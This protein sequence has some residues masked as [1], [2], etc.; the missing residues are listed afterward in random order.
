MKRTVLIKI[1]SFLCAAAALFACLLLFRAVET[2]SAG[3]PDLF[4]AQLSDLNER[5][6]Q[7]TENRLIVKSSRKIEDEHCIAS[8][9]GFADLYV[10]QY[11]SEGE[12]AR[13]LEYYSSLGSVQYAYRDAVFTADEFDGT[14]AETT[15]PDAAESDAGSHLSWGAD[16]LGVDGFYD[17]IR[18]KYEGSELPDI[19]VAV[20]DTGVDTDHPLLADRIAFEYGI[21]YCG[22]A[23]SGYDFEDDNDH[24]THV[25]GIIA[26]L[27]LPNVKLIPVKVMNQDGKGSVSNLLAG[28][29][30]VLSLRREG[31]PIAAYNMSFGGYGESEEEERLINLAYEEDI[32]AVASAGNESY[33]AASFSPARYERALTVSALAPGTIYRNFPH[34]TDY[35]NFGDC[36]D[37]CL[38]GDRV[39]SS[40]TGG[41]YAVK[42]GTSMAAPHATALVAL[43]ATYF[44]PGF[45]AGEIEKEIKKNTYDFGQAGKDDLYGYGVPTMAFAAQKFEIGTL[46]E[47]S[48]GEPFGIEHFHSDSLSLSIGGDF[49]EAE[50]ETVEIW[51]TLDG[52]VPTALSHET[53]TREIVLTDSALVRFMVCAVDETGRILGHGAL[54]EAT[55]YRGSSETNDSGTGFEIDENG[56]LTRYTSGLRNIKIPETVGGKKVT[57]LGSGLFCGLDVE[58][59]TAEA[60]LSV[61]D[62]PFDC[63][64]RLQRVLLGSTQAGRVAR[65]CFTLKELILPKLGEIAAAG[66]IPAPPLNLEFGGSK[67]FQGCFGL[68]SLFAPNVTAIPNAAFA[69]FGNL[70]K[71]EVNWDELDS[72]SPF[73]FRECGKLEQVDLSHVGTVGEY[74]FSGCTSLRGIGSLAQAEQIGNYAFDRCRGLR[75]ELSLGNVRKVGDHAFDECEKITSL[76]LSQTAEIGGYAFSCCTGL[77]EVDLTGVKRVG[78]HAFEECDGLESVLFDDIEF[79]GDYAFYGCGELSGELDLSG[80][81]RVGNYAF[82]HCGK[83]NSVVLARVPEI[84]AD[85]F[86]YCE[87]LSSADLTDAGAILDWAFF[88]TGLKTADLSTV[89]SVGAYAF[90]NCSQL[91]YLVLGNNENVISVR[92]TWVSSYHTFFLLIDKNYTGETGAAIAGYYPYRYEYPGYPYLIYASRELYTIVFRFGDGGIIETQYRAAREQITPP[93]GYADEERTV[94]VHSWAKENGSVAD[95][96]QAGGDAVFIVRESE[97]IPLGTDDY[98][99]NAKE[100]Y[101]ALYRRILGEGVRVGDPAVTAAYAAIDA[102]KREGT[103]EET[104]GTVNSALAVHAGLLL[105]G[106]RGEKDSDAFAEFLEHERS[107]L[108]LFCEEATR[109]GALADLN[110]FADELYARANEFRAEEK[111]EVCRELRN[112]TAAL[113]EG[114]HETSLGKAEEL[115]SGF[116]IA[117]KASDYADYARLLSYYEK[118]FVR[119]AGKWK[120]EEYIAG[121]ESDAIDGIF[122]RAAEE[123]DALAD[124]ILTVGEMGFAVDSIVEAAKSE[125]KVVLIELAEQRRTEAK[126]AV[127]DRTDSLAASL[128]GQ[129]RAGIEQFYAECDRLIDGTELSNY[130]ELI[131]SCERRFVKLAGKWRIEDLLGPSADEEIQAIAE[132]AKER[133]DT[134]PDEDGAS[135]RQSVDEIVETAEREIGAYLLEK[136]T[137]A[138]VAARDEMRERTQDLF[139]TIPEER[140]EYA[141]EI[142][143]GY[144]AQIGEAEPDR[145][146]EIFDACEKALACSAGV[147][148]LEDGLAGDPDRNLKEIVDRAVVAILTIDGKLSAEETKSAVEEIVGGAVEEMNG[149]RAERLARE[150]ESS[151][152]ALHERTDE[153]Y[154]SLTGER[155][156][157]AD[158]QYLLFEETL[159]E[160]DYYSCADVVAAFECAFLRQEG[161]WTVEDVIREGGEDRILE[162]I[163]R[164][165][166]EEIGEL[167]DDAEQIAPQ[168]ERIVDAATAEIS[169]YL[170][171][172]LA[173]SRTEWK[174]RVRE[175]TTETYR[176]LSAAHRESAE[177]LY[178][179]FDRRIDSGSYAELEQIGIS[180]LGAFWRESGKWEMEEFFGGVTEEAVREIVSQACEKID[181]ETDG[182]SDEIKAAVRGIISAAKDETVAYYLQ[183]EET[184]KTDAKSEL[185]D[186][187]TSVYGKLTGEERKRAD[188]LYLEFDEKIENAQ[189]SEISRLLE[190]YTSQI[191]SLYTETINL[192]WLIISLGIILFAEIASIVLL[193]GEKRERRTAFSVAPLLLT[194]LIVPASAGMICMIL[195]VLDIVGFF[196]ILGLVLSMRIGTKKERKERDRTKDE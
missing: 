124:R 134:L 150:R 29:E 177:T 38:P 77:T 163:F 75:G 137:A 5:F 90:S 65:S 31:L 102:A 49:P 9:S 103:L 40:V 32:L 6:S 78:D 122:A 186:R 1:L 107:T 169:Q 158:G 99:R 138:R 111:E 57:A 28:M 80:A 67:T 173:S 82:S 30:Y 3:D 153:I 36:V 164:R 15:E 187:T 140:R 121:N 108:S 144:E 183:K 127:R 54:S 110:A 176:A 104:L 83:L 148:R 10:L 98:K 76:V 62:Y 94:L 58:T 19:Y 66:S 174:A 190:S 192:W 71:I 27:T 48:R 133:V 21:G 42:S 61:G 96:A 136:L 175:E 56:T 93:G 115:Y 129:H 179:Q 26:D 125:I 113:L 184:E 106:V 23:T 63:C 168:I 53:Y 84:G 109:E 14:T 68:E 69:Y 152:A 25:S 92:S 131:S 12:A 147:W 41:G 22:D 157:W 132:R 149:Y 160:T 64:S 87:G 130:E 161:I 126:A 181:G 70:K 7:S 97:I 156:A 33:S 88:N 17:V 145:F 85:A 24:G 142:Y 52:S 128:P 116:G 13:A 118:L 191:S 46:P 171:D 86:A 47:L 20:L 74:A 73:A 166:E 141:E 81:Q 91:R 185:R 45:R 89:K 72:V 167:P 34:I 2:V 43:Y 4:A 60:D 196:A 51:Y 18:E 162:N 146:G 155:R 195:G 11:G 178:E 16:L 139:E 143:A 172:R 193:I 35:S 151:R 119:E 79:I 120:I 50:G 117:I 180:C 170:K 159:G 154:G 112:R 100:E 114:L 55:Y 37:L 165:V 182:S 8:A 188:A 189:R 101:D 44:G 123:I 59:V 194:T 39:R 95:F 105:G 135:L